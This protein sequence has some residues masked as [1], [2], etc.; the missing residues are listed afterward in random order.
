VAVPAIGIDADAL[1]AC[2]AQELMHGHAVAL[3]RDVPQRLLEA[4]D[5]APEVHGPALGREV[6]VRHVDE[7]RDVRSVPSHQVARQP[8]DV[9]DDARIAVGLGIALAPSVRPALR[10]DLDEEQVLAAA[11]IRQIGRDSFDTHA[12]DSTRIRPP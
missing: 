1:A 6:V 11:E 9:G 8:F 3:A 5:R 10:L 4:A 7:V 12:R 2:P